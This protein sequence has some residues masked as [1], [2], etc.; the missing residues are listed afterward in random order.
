[1]RSTDFG[2]HARIA[3]QQRTVG[4][5]RPVLAHLGVK[6]VAAARVHLQ[7]GGVVD[8]LH[9]G[10]EFGLTAQVQ[11]EVNAQAGG[12]GHRINQA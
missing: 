2:P 9:I 12:L 6:S 10:P 1:M 4:Q 11:R 5:L 8:P 7:V 3:W